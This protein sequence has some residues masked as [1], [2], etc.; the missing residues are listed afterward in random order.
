MKATSATTSILFR[1]FFMGF[2]LSFAETVK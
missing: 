1:V 2:S